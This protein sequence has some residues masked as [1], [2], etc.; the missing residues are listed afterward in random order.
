VEKSLPVPNMKTRAS[1]K[2]CY[3]Q[4]YYLIA[5]ISIGSGYWA[6]AVYSSSWVAKT[7]ISLDGSM[8]ILLFQL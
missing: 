1:G 5:S 4:I 2:A 8:Y 3:T 6:V 7:K